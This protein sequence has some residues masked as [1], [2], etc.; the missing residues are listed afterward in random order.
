MSTKPTESAARA[1]PAV[2][3]T[4]DLPAP[5]Y[6]VVFSS[7]RTNV[8]DEGYAAMA[9]RMVE[10]GSSMPGFLGIESAR[11]AD[12]FGITV[13]YWA[14][15]AAIRDWQRHAE[16]LEAQRSG[17]ERWYVGF[18]LRICRVERSRGFRAGPTV[19]P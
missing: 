8:D 2:A 15:E 7:V 5:C 10:L 9:T 13:S 3:L 11:G 17:R 18:E 14:S 12:G 16:H 6:A 4:A 1:D 19:E